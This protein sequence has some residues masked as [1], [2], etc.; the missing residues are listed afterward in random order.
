[1][2]RLWVI[3]HAKSSWSGASAG[4]HD[5]DLNNRGRRDGPVMAAW[6]AAQDLPPEHIVAS[7]ALRTRRTADYLVDG[8]GLTP[9]ALECSADLYL[10]PPARMLAVVRA[11]PDHLASAAVVAHNPGVTDFANNLLETPPIDDFPTFGIAA[12]DIPGRWADTAAGSG[13]LVVFR[14]P[15]TLDSIAGT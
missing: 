9:D 10:A 15:K 3:R 1:M 7:D 11:L 14:S 4:D 5:R 12:I 8:C 6:L 13:H 2:P